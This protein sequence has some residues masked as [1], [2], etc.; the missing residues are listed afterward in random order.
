M[1]RLLFLL[2]WA[3]PLLGQTITTQPVSQTVQVGA[4]ATFTVT[5]SAGPCRSFWLINGAGHYGSVASTISY[6]LPPATLA[7]NGWQ[8]QV[9]LYGCAGGG[10]NL[11]SN[12]VTLTVTPSVTLSSIAITTPSP[13]IG[14]GQTD[15][16]T[17]T[18]SYSDGSTQNLTSAATWA[19]SAATIASASGGTVLGLTLGTTNVTATVGS[20][21]AST[22]VTV[23]PSLGITFTPTN[24]DGTI[25]VAQLVVNQIVLN[26]D[27]TQTATPVLTLPDPGGATSS[28]LLYNP[29]VLYD[30]IFFLNN[31]SVGQPLVFSPVLM[32][33]MM[34]KIKSMSYSVVLCV[35]TC[36]A[37]AIKSMSFV[38]Q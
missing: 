36:P 17:A 5:A 7:M 6:S 8:I 19:S 37:G 35:S 9:E 31:Q 23:E 13:I 33:V 24:E 32:S 38:A 3:G 25:P 15:S 14:I 1:K 28:S 30:A 10:A 11:N 4:V 27:G 34:P 18:G 26:S 12:T 22:T 20:L 2:L 29:A 16:L 21:S